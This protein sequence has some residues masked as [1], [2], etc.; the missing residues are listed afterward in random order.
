MK[1][2]NIIIGFLF[3]S[4]FTHAQQLES[5]IQ[6][7]WLNSA[8]IQSF[9]LRYAVAKEK[10]KEVNTIPNTQ[11]GVGYF[12]S[13]PETRTGAQRAKFSIQQ[14]LPWFGTITAREN[15]ST[16]MAEA[17]YVDI[18]IMKR[19]L[20]LSISQS[21]YKLFA[22]QNKQKILEDKILLLQTYEK[23]ALT[24]VEVGK[25]SA[26][27]VLRLQIRQNEL[28]QHKG[29]LKE[30]F[31]AEQIVFNALLNRDSD[32]DII[33]P[34]EMNIPLEDPITNNENLQLNPELL[35]YDKIY[36]SIK[37]SELLNRKE[38]APQIGFGLDYIP[39]SER[40]DVTISDNGKD[41]IM[42]MVSFSIPIFNKRHDSRTRQNELRQQEITAQKEERLN[43]MET[44]LGKAISN[45]NTARIKYNTQKE[46]LKQAKN[47]EEI[48]IKSY[49]TGTID[50]NDV[51][52]IQE[53]Q[54]KFQ[55][56]QIESIQLYYIEAAI[57]NYLTN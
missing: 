13:E 4:V 34:G 47:A 14:K 15:Y 46:N 28:K 45:R 48:L 50:F 25:A 18:V 42:P 39:V 57:I 40:N 8:K 1:H 30:S 52:D 49:E 2:L 33:V 5:Y 53:L 31:L 44:I 37:Q 23:L 43:R 27:D 32:I 10:I 55:L 21:Y 19:K 54:L 51:L 56:N 20:A 41:I 29:V 9:E 24:S 12:V 26:V 17:E 38:K 11:F 16:A 35:K 3:I 22:I 36:E 6:E 7:G